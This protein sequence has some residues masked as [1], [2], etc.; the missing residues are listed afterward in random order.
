MNVQVSLWNMFVVNERKTKC[1]VITPQN[2]TIEMPTLTVNNKVIPIVDKESYL[3]YNL[4]NDCKDNEAIL[5]EKGSI[6]A[7]GNMLLQKFKHC[8]DN[9]KI[10]LFKAF[11]S[12]I[13]CCAVWSC[14]D[15]MFM[16]DLHVAHNNIFRLFFTL[17]QP[18]SVS[19]HFRQRNV[20]NF[21]LIRRKQCCSLFKRILESTNSLVH[22]LADSIHFVQSKIFMAWA[23][24]IF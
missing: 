15:K 4:T 13:Y 5:K 22:C 9:V 14:F 10:E 6:Y 19:Y 24:D 3:G 11:C 7:R 8:S 17:Q 1:M 12:S 20:S 21:P 23:N 18:C 16:D 2:L